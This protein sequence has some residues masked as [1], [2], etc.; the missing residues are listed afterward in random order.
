MSS[1]D[2]DVISS[3]LS[4]GQQAGYV[5]QSGQIIGILKQMKDTQ[6]RGACDAVGIRRSSLRR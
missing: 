4:Q 1:V 2:R 6:A 3:F 5:P